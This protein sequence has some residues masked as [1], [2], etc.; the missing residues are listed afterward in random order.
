[1]NKRKRQIIQ[2]ARELFI[3]KGFNNTS[4]MDIIEAA[5]IS[6]GTFY[7]H[8]TSKNE[9]LIAILE[10]SREELVNARYQI[11]SN[12]DTSDINLLINQ[13]AMGF[14]LSRKQNFNEIFSTTFD[15]NDKDIK[16]IIEKHMVI[17]IDWLA[18]RFVDIYG[19][20]IRPIS[21]ECAIHT[22]AIIVFSLHFIHIATGVKV[23]PESIIKTALN[24]V[25]AIIP[26]I[27]ETGDVVFNEEIV[28]A[29]KVK[30]NSKKVSKDFIVKQLEGFVNQLTKND[31]EKGVELA[32][33][34]LDELKKP[35][36][37]LYVLE[38]L[39]SSFNSA[40]NNTSHQK[41]AKEISNAI[42]NYL[43]SKKPTSCN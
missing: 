31:S 33:Y 36:E 4:I 19:E 26:N 35:E 29:L 2:A 8:F 11:A 24:R 40:F 23:A 41:E 17:E 3:K 20:K 32:N 5:N 39:I 12:K 28:Q 16:E 25:I 38:A 14:H 9:C 37:K 13:I 43:N 21:Y 6:K 18:N 1:M 22:F 42:W 15:S 30:V 34:L 27:L 7:N 10:E